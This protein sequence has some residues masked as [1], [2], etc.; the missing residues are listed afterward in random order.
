MRTAWIRIY[1]YII[2]YI[3]IYIYIYIYARIALLFRENRALSFPKKGTFS[4]G[5]K[6]RGGGDLPPMPPGSA[7][8]DGQASDDLFG[9]F[10]ILR[11]CK[12]SLI[13]WF[14]KSFSLKN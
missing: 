7:A 9:M 2:Y 12:A 11:K 6:S 10:S 1:I 5:T 3:Y 13:A 14:L 4:Q 8:S